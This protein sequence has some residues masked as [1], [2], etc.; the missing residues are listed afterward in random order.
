MTEEEIATAKHILNDY[1]NFNGDNL[2][3]VETTGIQAYGKY[4]KS[5]KRISDE[6]ITREENLLLDYLKTCGNS[7]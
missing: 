5:I 4:L 3:D 6:E 1:E 2:T 7:V